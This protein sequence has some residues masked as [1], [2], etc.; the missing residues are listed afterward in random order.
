MYVL[1]VLVMQC[2]TCAGHGP[3]QS[4][5]HVDEPWGLHGPPEEQQAQ[6]WAGTHVSLFVSQCFSCLECGVRSGVL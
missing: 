5:G 2:L 6:I 1:H 3:D 4:T